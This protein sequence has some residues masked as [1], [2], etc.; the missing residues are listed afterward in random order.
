LSAEAA[1]TNN[2]IL[3]KKL[4]KLSFGIAGLIS[5]Y[6]SNQKNVASK[7]SQ[8]LKFF[9]GAMFLK[10]VK[11]MNVT[12]LADYFGGKAE[13]MKFIGDF[14]LT[15][16]FQNYISKYFNVHLSPGKVVL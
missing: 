5:T 2:A 10:L 8:D 3:R 15:K 7:L 16:N 14:I 13:L 11:E 6:F 12:D 1:D 4:E 9:D